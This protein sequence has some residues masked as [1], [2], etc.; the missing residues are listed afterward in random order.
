MLPKL[1]IAFLVLAAGM[2]TMAAAQTRKQND[3]PT[4]GWTYPVIK[5]YGRAWPLP[6]ATVQP[7]QG[8]TYKVILGLSKESADPNEVLDGLAHTARLF[9]VFAAD[10]VPP[11][12]LKVVAICHD[13]AGYAA[14][15]N[16]SGYSSE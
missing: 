3:A 2:M 10:R 1:W 11:K 13:S 4:S 6:R 7:Q 12:N 14:M 9:N 8:H 15:S 5:D 16:R